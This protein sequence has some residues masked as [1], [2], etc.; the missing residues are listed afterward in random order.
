[1]N[2]AKSTPRSSYCSPSLGAIHD[3]AYDKD[4]LRGDVLDRIFP[5]FSTLWN[6]EL[7]CWDSGRD[8]IEIE[9]VFVDELA[10]W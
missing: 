5:H 2:H 9:V 3:G 10:L 8:I 1:M 4:K 7:L 6:V